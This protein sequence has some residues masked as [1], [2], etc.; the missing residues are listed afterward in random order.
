[1]DT[2]KHDQ[3]SIDEIV[4]FCINNG[5]VVEAIDGKDVGEDA[6]PLLK[7]AL[8]NSGAV[9]IECVDIDNPKNIVKRELIIFK[10][11]K[12]NF[13]AINRKISPH[14]AF[15]SR[16]PGKKCD[17]AGR[18]VIFITEEDYLTFIKMKETLSSN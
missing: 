6:R 5:Q 9:E 1:M 18:H 12:G 3:T 7:S 8:A 10:E 16:F 4:E 13:T 11:D 2:M 14:P 15:I 17:F